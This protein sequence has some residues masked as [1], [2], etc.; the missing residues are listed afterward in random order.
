MFINLICYHQ[1]LLEI[2]NDASV[3]GTAVIMISSSDE[4]KLAL[5]CIRAGAQDFLTKTDIS[6]FRL[7]RAII[8]ARTRAEL[9]LELSTSYNSWN[10]C[11]HFT[12]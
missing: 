4:E 9:E 10:E 5:E 7:N 12:F 6:T 8:T 3:S 2:K 11:S 1:V